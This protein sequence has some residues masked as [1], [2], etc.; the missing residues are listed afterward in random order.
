MRI[1]EG[2]KHHA[3]EVDALKFKFENPCSRLNLG[4]ETMSRGTIPEGIRVS[5][6]S[7]IRQGWQ[8]HI[9]NDL[10]ILRMKSCLAI[11]VA[12]CWTMKIS[13]R[14]FFSLSFLRFRFSFAHSR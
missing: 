8:A 2:D 3:R 13:C 6:S 12:T 7:L 5:S 4:L 9:I 10:A 11:I 1:T 14:I